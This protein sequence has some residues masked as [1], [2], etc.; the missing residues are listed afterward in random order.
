MPPKI[1][2]KRLANP[3]GQLRKGD[4]EI[5]FGNE[6]VGEL[7]RTGFGGEIEWTLKDFNGED[8]IETT[9]HSTKRNAIAQMKFLYGGR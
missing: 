3:K 6:K 7:F 5:Y 2:T 9:G 1:K 4:Y 8:G